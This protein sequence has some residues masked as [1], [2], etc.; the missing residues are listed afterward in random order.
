MSA[1]SPRDAGTLSRAR[2]QRSLW[3][4]AT[5]INVVVV[6]LAAF[7]L[8][9]SLMQHRARVETLGDNLTRVLEENLAGSFDKINLALLGIVEEFGRQQAA[10]GVE[11]E[12]LDDF[13][14]RLH[15]R[16]PELDG[17]RVT[18]AAGTIQ[19]GMGVDPDARITTAD[20]DYFVK[21]REGPPDGLVFSEPLLGRISGKWT[22]A[23]A[24][25]LSEPDGSFA[26][27]VYAVFTIEHFMK[28]F[29]ALN[30]ERRS[31]VALLSDRFILIARYPALTKG[32]NVIGQNKPTREFLEQVRGGRMEGHYTAISPVDSLERL[33]TF[34]KLAGYPFYVIVTVPLE[35]ALANWRTEAVTVLAMVA[36]L[37]LV[38]VMS[39]RLIYLGWSRQDQAAQALAQARDKLEER[40]AERTAELIETI[41]ALEDAKDQAETAGRAKADFLANVSHELKTPLNPI[42]AYTDM[43]LDS[44]LSDDQRE[45][46]TEVRKAAGRLLAMIENLIELTRMDS[47]Q[48]KFAQVGPHSVLDLLERELAP[49]AR[50]KGLALVKR[51]DPAIP[52]LIETD[53]DLL[54]LALFKIGENAVKFTPA[55]E[56]ELSLASCGGW[57]RFAVRDTGIGVAPDK[58]ERITAGLSQ[59]EAPLTKRHRGLGLGLATVH[60]ALELLGGRLEVESEEGKGSTFSVCLPAGRG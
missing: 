15:Y 54:R 29:S 58:I 9:G 21:L 59:A 52:A 46:L 32:P 43:A 45:N 26:G 35:T 47:R 24:R 1:P 50:E 2:L 36:A 34:R 53:L 10:G 39:A 20:R 57:V 11:R 23:I 25:R 13:I 31:S 60:K 18:D 51:A 3:L 5:L 55:G 44:E 28:K 49:L 30:L 19:Y 56:I 40:V 7:E 6:G 22:M 48:A 33:F 8:H 14:G 4:V 17:I 38:T 37:F 41:E 16:V 12:A 27:A 42:V